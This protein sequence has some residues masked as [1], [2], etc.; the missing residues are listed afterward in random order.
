MAFIVGET[1]TYHS[2]KADIVTS[3]CEITP[4]GSIKVE[5]DREA[6]FGKDGQEIHRMTYPFIE[7]TSCEAKQERDAV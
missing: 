5:C 1:V 7:K 2:I 4:N 6:L 3:V